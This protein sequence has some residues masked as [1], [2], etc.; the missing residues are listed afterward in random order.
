MNETEKIKSVLLE[1]TNFLTQIGYNERVE[2]NDVWNSTLSYLNSDKG[3]AVEFE[4]D[5]RDVDVFVIVTILED[6]KLPSGYY[7]HKGKKVR[8]HLE[9]LFESEKIKG[10]DWKAI[11]R[12]RRELKEPNEYRLI[13]L[14]NSY[15]ILL[16]EVIDEIQQ[17]NYGIF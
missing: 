12:I 5:Y 2:K 1:K 10:G 9:N 8:V 17:L 11:A 15:C 13:T 14:I 7:M 4:I 3:L 6:G 16:N